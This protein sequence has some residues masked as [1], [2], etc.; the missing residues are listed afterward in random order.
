MR[1][2]ERIVD[3]VL[4]FGLGVAALAAGFL[5]RPRA[6]RAPHEVDAIVAGEARYTFDL[7]DGKI[8]VADVRGG[9][10]LLLEP[11][12]VVD[13][14]VRPLVG[15]STGTSAHRVVEVV[16][17]EVKVKVLLRVDHGLLRARVLDPEA[18]APHR[19][20][21]RY[22]IATG[23]P[24]W[25]PGAGELAAGDALLANAAL[26]EQG[27][28]PF[29]VAAPFGARIAL[30]P[31]SAQRLDPD[32]R[33]EAEDDS[34]AQEPLDGGESLADAGA[35]AGAPEGR[36]PLA[37]LVFTTEHAAMAAAPAPE[38]DAG[39]D[40]TTTAPPKDAG[41]D[42]REAG[43][44]TSRAR[45]AQAADASADL[46]LRDAASGDA[47][48]EESEGDGDDE[49][50]EPGDA[51][52]A[53]V[54]TDV[55]QPSTHA[56]HQKAT[57]DA[58]PRAR[59]R[60]RPELVVFLGRSNESAYGQLFKLL[61]QKTARV[62]GR[63]TGATA[64]A[65][66]YGVDDTGHPQVRALLEENGQFSVDAPMSVDHWF[67]LEG[68]ATSPPIRYP[69]GTGWPLVL[70]LS[71]GGEIAIKVTDADTRSSVPARV[72]VHGIDGTLDPSFGP[73]FRASGAG[74][75][76][77]LLA[78]EL[79][80]P[81]PKG[82]YRVQ[83][84]HGIEWTVDAQVV[85]V[86]SGKR[87]RLDL[88]LRHVVPTK[89]LVACDLHVHARPSFDSL[90]SVEDRVTTLVTA[91]VEFAV[92]TEHNIAGD[93]GPATTALGLGARFGSVTGVEVTTFG[94]RYGHFGVFP[95]PTDVPVPPYRQVRA[96][97]MFEAARKGDPSRVIQVNHPRL[98]KGIGYFN[99]VGFDAKSGIVPVKM[100]TDF[101]AVEVYNGY[102]IQNGAM[103]EA[104][105]KD[106]LSLLAHGKR[107]A[108]TGSSDSHTVQYNWAG[109]PRTY[110]YQD[111]PSAGEP[112]HPVDTK[113]VV[114]ALK[115]GRSI[116]TSGPVIELDVGGG[117]PGEE[118]S[119]RADTA[120]A[121]VRV[122]AAPWVD[123]TSLEL[124]LDGKSLT[125]KVVPS[126]PSRV[127]LEEGTLAEAQARAVRLEADVPVPLTPGAH[128]V[129]AVARGRRKA[130]DVLPFM[131][132]VPMG[133]T[134]PVWITRGP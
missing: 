116:V 128:F 80:S 27:A 75:L 100:R 50:A 126:R 66:L 132:Y 102:E 14:T 121:H 120:T 31:A 101:D 125:T 119:T 117:K 37:R 88:V 104:V 74:P 56:E 107:F 111:T 86:K 76:V 96:G 15:A 28:R 44:V 124:Y 108:A 73:D 112:G 78:G 29:I 36:P 9:E 110:A 67:A 57:P 122:S 1:G 38:A 30:V 3:P 34:G 105:L 46:E 23:A 109:Y 10:E 52:P 72:W 5:L 123:V 77:D 48:E 39:V 79:V 127:G 54:P 134:N 114:A 19:V 118:V 26:I 4:A 84:T 87:E 47:G 70:D 129:V 17:G 35:E 99:I 83:A 20:E 98:G 89:S 131:P 61:G 40:G 113:A 92:P 32:P 106:W 95:Y 81:L 133:F 115:A 12:L 8:R 91:G 41:G 18:L 85:E 71:P 25:V 94:P 82:R 6:E 2:R 64:R 24:V 58:R 21:L 130:D 51:S 55:S 65:Q 90:V 69:P 53:V 22:E 49:G 59:R 11:E 68:S 13:G 93:Y 62:A 7:T 63:V 16:A 45:D 103:V 43:L 60:P 42:A 97:Q 33:G